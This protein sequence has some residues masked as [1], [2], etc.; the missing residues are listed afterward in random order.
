VQLA[1]VALGERRLLPALVA[2]S[3]RLHA[4][5]EAHWDDLRIGR[6]HL[7]PAL[8]VRFGQQ[9]RG[10]AQRIEAATT[11]LRSAV[12]ACRAL[13][14]GGTAV[15]TGVNADPGFATAV[16]VGV[17]TATGLRVHET[18][19]H[20]T[21]QAG[22][23]LLLGVATDAAHA[24]TALYQIVNDV[25]WQA[26]ALAELALP[27]M[28]PGS[29]MM[30]GKVNPVVC[31][32]V[33]MA[34][35]QVIGNGTVTSFANT[36]GQ[37]ELNTMVPLVAHGVLQSVELLAGAA[38]AFEAECLCG[39]RIEGGAAEAARR[40]P[41]LATL[42]VPDIGHDR[43]AEI[44]RAAAEQRRPVADVAR[45]SSG[46]EASRIEELLDPDRVCG[47]FGHRR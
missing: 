43:A 34:C 18:D 17:A 9:F 33:L 40:A 36:Q 7:M 29:S 8:P 14:L 37:F 5:A 28:Q 45:E 30:P 27:P 13:P 11:R 26:S 6:T 10:Y 21:G 42:L 23:D 44:A 46:L 2:T 47:R 32:A 16:C 1:V 12:D 20:L 25:R 15:G 35:A 41:T 31:E 4:L 39:L 3:E 24:A 19:R 22:H 38:S